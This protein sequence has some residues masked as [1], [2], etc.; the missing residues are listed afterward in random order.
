MWR[1]AHWTVLAVCF[2]GVL[3]AIGCGGSGD[4][5]TARGN[6]RVFV[7]EENHPTIQQ[8]ELDISRI[9]AMRGDTWETILP[10]TR[11]IRLMGNLNN[12]TLLVEANL[13][14]GLY[15]ALRLTVTG[16]RITDKDGRQS[17]EVDPIPST[18]PTSFDIH[19]AEV[20][21]VVI[22]FD[23]SQSVRQSVD[24]TYRFQPIF[25]VSP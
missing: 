25:S 5:A 17:A 18:V 8:V 9:V 11:S 15:R 24:G 16:A 1:K 21:P 14:T 12:P 3:G 4:G 2:F 10:G 22:D 7:A 20:T 13:P 19:L 6:V 23:L